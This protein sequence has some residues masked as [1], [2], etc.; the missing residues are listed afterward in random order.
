MS[1]GGTEFF[2]VKKGQFNGASNPRTFT[3]HYVQAVNNA[4]D[5]INTKLDLSSAPDYITDTKTDIDLDEDRWGLLSALV[6]VWLLDFGNR[7]GG[8]TPQLAFARQENAITQ[9]LLDRDL[10][11][12]AA[13]TD[14]ETIGAFVS[15]S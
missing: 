5:T 6:D 3:G 8:L 12:A 14:G 10:A 15:I 1:I 11:A 9:A 2:D 4:L 13:A 7:S